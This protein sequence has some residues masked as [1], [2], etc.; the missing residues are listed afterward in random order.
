MVRYSQELRSC[1]DSLRKPR[2]L[3]LPGLGNP[4]PL[5]HPSILGKACRAVKERMV[6]DSN[7]GSSRDQGDVKTSPDPRPWKDSGPSAP[8]S[9]E[10]PTQSHNMQGI[11][12][13]GGRSGRQDGEGHMVSLG[14]LRH[15]VED[16]S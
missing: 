10:R 1:L 9:R 3:H 12:A 11:Q 2:E 7:K 15:C 16:S 8:L 6:P 13:A 5:S 4:I 14:E